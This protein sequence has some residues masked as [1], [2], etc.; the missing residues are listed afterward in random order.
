[1]REDIKKADIIVIK[2]GTSL[3]VSPE[4]GIIE[5]AISKLASVLAQLMRSGKKIIL[6]SSGAVGAGTVQLGEV[7]KYAAAAVGQ[8]ILTGLYE[9]EF[10]KHDQKIGQLLLSRDILT[11]PENR[12][13]F[14]QTIQELL[15]RR[16]LPIVNE[17]D[18]VTVDEGEH[19]TKFEDNDELSLLIAEENPTINEEAQMIRHLSKIDQRLFEASDPSLGKLSRGGIRSKLKTATGALTANISMVLANGRDPHVLYDIL[20]GREIGTLFKKQQ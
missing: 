10:K 16:I 19:R 17:N 14:D 3:L 7:S 9:A 1:M 2:V 11:V 18:A 4:T 13:A 20:A 12:Q 15:A 8:G 5:S 6:V